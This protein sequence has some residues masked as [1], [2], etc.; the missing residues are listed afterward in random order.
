MKILNSFNAFDF[1]DI[2]NFL[3][4]LSFFMIYFSVKLIIS[5]LFCTQVRVDF[6]LT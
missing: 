4:V 1:L 2:L 5:D 6:D 3:N